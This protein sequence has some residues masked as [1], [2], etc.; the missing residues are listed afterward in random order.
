M[1]MVGLKYLL[2]TAAAC[3]H[4]A[5]Q[6][7]EDTLLDISY[8]GISDKCVSALNTTVAKC[9]GFLITASLDNGRLQPEELSDLCTTACRSGLNNVR[10]TIATAC[11]SAKDVMEFRGMVWPATVL[12][13]RFI[14]K[15]NVSCRT[16]SS[17][18]KFCHE[19]FLS[20]LPSGNASTSS[21][22]CSD[23]MLG[24]SQSQ[25]NSPFGYQADFAASFRNLTKSCSATRYTFTTPT[26][27]AISTIAPP[28]TPERPTCGSPYV[29]KSNDTC[30][31]IA[32]AN[33]VA[34]WSVLRAG[35][36]DWRCK[37]LA[38]GDLLC[39]PKP[40]NL[41]RVQYDD[42][43]EAIVSK[44][45]GL[46]M[47][48]F[49][50]W[51]PVINSLCTNMDELVGH[52]LC[53]TA[54]GGVPGDEN[55]TVPPPTPTADP[56]TAVPKP[57]NGKDETKGPCAKWYTIQDGDKCES[58]SVRDGIALRDF[59]FLNPSLDSQCTNLLLGIAYCVQAVGNIATYPGYPYSSTQSQYTL[60]SPTYSTTTRTTVPSQAPSST[61]RPVLPLASGSLSGC[62]RNV[63]HIPVPKRADQEVQPDEPVLTEDVNSCIYVSSLY[64]VS[65]DDFLQWNPSLKAIKPC[66]LQ[67]GFRYC[68]VKVAPSDTPPGDDTDGQSTAWT[69]FD[70]AEDERIT[71]QQ[72]KAWN[73]WAGDDC[74]KGLYTN[75]T[76][77]KTRAICYNI[78]FVTVVDDFHAETDVDNIYSDF[79]IIF[80]RSYTDWNLEK[81]QQYH[82]TLD[83]F[84]AWNP[85]VGTNCENLWK[86]YAYCVGVNSS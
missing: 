21:Q 78:L 35:G 85:A 56:G 12:I 69:C 63:E 1:I 79:A 24:V 75:L 39:L 23:C 81:L 59:Y 77:N 31:S 16:D 50:S 44:R 71:L 43:C 26:P 6:Q 61:T 4:I 7:F 27:Y 14:Y 32:V 11:N 82:I 46:N 5:A 25:L 22:N 41:Y 37:N 18:G 9:P 52:M 29:V 51:N 8:P 2:L 53:V 57:T 15:Y 45:S 62:E 10:Q 76:G 68:A 54:P 74:D 67:V 40:C 34:T 38:A 72:L 64:D 80:F 30:D 3:R 49:M 60:A 73:P 28:P 83:Q 70:I 17:T 86:G 66:Q 58:V 36:L 13:D 48:S 84:Y 42:T 20:W 19:I 33:G 65:I 55:M 47:A